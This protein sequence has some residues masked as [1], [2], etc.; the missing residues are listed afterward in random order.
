MGVLSR[1]RFSWL[2]DWKDLTAIA[3][4]IVVVGLGLWAAVLTV[5]GNL[6]VVVPQK[7]YR[8][9]QPSPGQLREWVNRLGI[10]TVINLR[11]KS[12]D[13]EKEQ[14]VAK[15]LGVQII[16]LSLSSHRI[17][18]KPLMAELV[19]AIETAQ[20]PVLIHCQAGVDRAGTA[21][22]MAA[23]AIGN[24]DYYKARWQ[25]Y[26]APGPWKRR[27]Y[28]G[29]G[30]RRLYYEHISDV[31]VLYERYCGQ[32]GVKANDWQHLKE[33]IGRTD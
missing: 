8:S 27:A 2:S 13:A 9:A 32:N 29:H 7:V 20:L 6:H 16:S 1:T 22:T 24:V 3:L 14:A 33:W 23:M 4:L 26:V 19:K 25:A 28:N 12:P 17:P 10:R 15:Q 5:Q 18:S 21:S 31:L 11:G 30:S